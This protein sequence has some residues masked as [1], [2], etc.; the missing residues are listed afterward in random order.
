MEHIDQQRDELGQN[1][2]Q[3]EDRV[4]GMADWRTQ[5]QERPMLGVGLAMGGG[6]LLG[7]LLGG[8]GDKKDKSESRYA[9]MYGAYQSPSYQPTQ[10]NGGDSSMMGWVTG[11]RGPSQATHQSK[12]E[13]ADKLDTLRAALMGMAVTR[14]Q[15][16]LNEALP[17]FRDEV[18]KAEQKKSGQGIMSGMGSTSAQ[19]RSS[20]FQSEAASIS[21]PGS[22]FGDVD[23]PLGPGAAG[24][25]QDQSV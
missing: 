8:G 13:A 5:F 16:F 14:A 2:N 24:Y 11:Q 22:S 7:M 17:G 20:G 1:I 12:R 10:H 19:P 3:L 4:R 9:S 23:E 15:D 25:S 21:R 18:D 6:M